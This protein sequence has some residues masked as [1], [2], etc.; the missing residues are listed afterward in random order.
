MVFLFI[1]INSEVLEAKISVQ[2]Y[3]IIF[4]N[5][6][7][8]IFALISVYGR[9]LR[10]LVLKTN[11]DLWLL[12]AELRNICSPDEYGRQTTHLGTRRRSSARSSACGESCSDSD[13]HRIASIRAQL[14]SMVI[15]SPVSARKGNSVRPINGSILLLGR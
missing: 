4:F 9:L 3:L 1:S 12:S 6:Y 2:K 14:A 15:I 13:L 11:I 7:L 8:E 10:L 5:L